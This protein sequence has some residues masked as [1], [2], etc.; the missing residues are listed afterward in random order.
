MQTWT[1]PFVF[2]SSELPII[3]IYAFYI[4]IL[5]QWIRNTKDASVMQRF[6]IPLLALAGC[7]FM[8]YASIVSHGIENSL[9]SDCVRCHY[10]PWIS[11]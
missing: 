5:I 11:L 6:V 3:T 10:A 7:C 9:V 2:D 1:G 8:I 4:P